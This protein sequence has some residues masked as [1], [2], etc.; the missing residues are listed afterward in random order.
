MPAQF[1]VYKRTYREHTRE[2]SDRCIR[3]MIDWTLLADDGTK[4]DGYDLKID[5]IR[6]GLERGFKPFDR[7]KKI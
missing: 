3:I 4:V 2:G 1:I 6:A 7:S 5:A